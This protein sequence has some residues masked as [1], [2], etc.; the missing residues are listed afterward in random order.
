MSLLN[1]PMEL[2]LHIASF[3]VEDRDLAQL[4]RT[5]PVCYHLLNRGLYDQ[6]QRN[7]T[8]NESDQNQTPNGKL[9]ALYWAIVHHR[10]DIVQR[11]IAYGLDLDKRCAPG[12]SAL[13][14]ACRF[15]DYEVAK[16]LLE[17]HKINNSLT[18][19]GS[20][21][22]LYAAASNGNANV[23]GLLL[24]HVELCQRSAAPGT[25]WP[26]DVNSRDDRFMTPLMIAGS[27]NYNEVVAL[28]LAVPGIDLRGWEKPKLLSTSVE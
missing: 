9:P 14:L 16:L 15:G 6:N 23:V 4:V 28:L 5:H 24:D 20:V 27:K 3:L 12:Y 10:V 8:F 22:P 2:F 11:V 17:S 18:D 1:L 26:I 19:R 21:A 13:Y 25:T 7:T